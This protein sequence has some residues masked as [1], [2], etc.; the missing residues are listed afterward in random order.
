VEIR[1]FASGTSAE[2]GLGKEKIRAEINFVANGIKAG[3]GAQFAAD[4]VIFQIKI[5]ADLYLSQG[6]AG[7][8]KWR[9]LRAARFADLAWRGDRLGSVPNP[10]MRQWLAQIYLSALTYE[11]MSSQLELSEAGIL[12]RE[13]RASISLQEVLG[14]LFQSQIFEDQEGSEFTGGNDKLREELDECLRD[15]E[16]LAQLHEFGSTLWEPI[17]IEWESWLR[18]VYHSTMAAAF[19][20]SV[21]DL[22]PSIDQD[23]LSVDLDRGPVLDG[24]K[25]G[26]EKDLVEVW[27]TERNPGGN[28]LVEE[29][30]RRYSEDPRRFFSTVRAN[31]G[32][33]EF[34]IIEHQLGKILN[35]LSVDEDSCNSESADLIRRF[36]ASESQEEM[37]RTFKSLRRSLLLEGFSPFHGFLVA[38]GNRILR[39]GSGP[40]TDQYLSKVLKQ[41]Q[42]EEERIGIE[43]DLRVMTY[44][45]SRS[46]EI[47]RVVTD[48]GAPPAADRGAWRS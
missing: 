23:D 37:A 18:G 14:L 15:P 16:L 45:L 11:A 39:P 41:W 44:F 30:M 33:G 13:G 7:S 48:V 5:P 9:A 3:L 31:I 34:E 32:M 4:S 42:L 22:C 17:T 40:A 12:F 1:R 27:F 38:I 24:E 43:I 20:R 19:L 25:I 2:I 47:D 28:G 8:E 35:L 21:I 10:F 46:D 36:R 26:L 6:D 29:F